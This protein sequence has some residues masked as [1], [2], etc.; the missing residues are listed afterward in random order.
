MSQWPITISAS[1]SGPQ[2]FSPNPLTQVALGDSVFWSNDDTE[3]HW[4]GLAD[5]SGTIV[6]PLFYMLNQIAP[7]SSSTAFAPTEAGTYIYVCSLP[8]HGHERGTFQVA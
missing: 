2:K 8:G 1:A 7:D 4:P 3:P 5:G 6:N